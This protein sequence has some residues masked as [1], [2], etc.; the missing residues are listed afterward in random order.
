MHIIPLT[1]FVCATLIMGAHLGIH[2]GP[3]P[4][5]NTIDYNPTEFMYTLASTKTTTQPSPAVFPTVPEM[6]LKSCESMNECSFNLEPIST[7]KTT[8]TAWMFSPASI[9]ATRRVVST[10][11]H[12][13]TP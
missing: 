13:K 11:L 3:T 9:Y 6:M 8:R 5:S 12:K 4:F 10:D 7:E 1:S 2:L